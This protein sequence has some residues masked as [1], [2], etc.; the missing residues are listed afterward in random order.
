MTYLTNSMKAR[1][2]KR[3]VVD[4]LILRARLDLF[5]YLSFQRDTF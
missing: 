1:E 4:H 3:R 5:I 2:K